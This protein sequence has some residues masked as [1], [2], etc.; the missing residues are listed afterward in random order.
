[1]SDPGAAVPVTARAPLPPPDIHGRRIPVHALDFATTRVM[2]IHRAMYSPIF[3]NRRS[4]SKDVYRFDAPDDEYGVLYASE[5]FSACMAETV[6]RDRF[7]H[8]SAPILLSES[9]LGERSLSLLSPVSGTILRLADLTQP[10][11]TLG[12]TAQILSDPDYTAPNAW[13]MAIFGHPQQLDGIYFRSRYA[14]APSIAIF[15]RCQ[16][17]QLG[18]AIPLPAFPELGPFLD[19]Y[20]IGLAP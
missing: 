18:P 16:L 13:S 2:R 4:A 1:M 14:N 9:M 3:Y 7:Q 10:L 15:D 8:Q 12:F 5:S 19:A 11:F 17:R 20:E 6:I